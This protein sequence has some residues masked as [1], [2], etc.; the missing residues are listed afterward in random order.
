M[1]GVCAI[2]KPYQLKSTTD[3][4]IVAQQPHVLVGCCCRSRYD[5][6][7]SLGGRVMLVVGDARG[8]GIK[9]GQNKLA[10]AIFRVVSCIYVGPQIGMD[11]K[12]ILGLPELE[13]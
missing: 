11:P 8:S 9:I 7:G 10:H 2:P 4:S 12:P 5:K 6:G 3:P 13:Y 1:V